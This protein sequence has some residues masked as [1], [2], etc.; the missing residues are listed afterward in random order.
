MMMIIDITKIIIAT[1]T[2]HDL[3]ITLRKCSPRFQNAISTS[4]FKRELVYSFIP[5]AVSWGEQ[6]KFMKYG[7]KDRAE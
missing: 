2:D 4:T 1:I 5:L 3:I 6:D 7:N